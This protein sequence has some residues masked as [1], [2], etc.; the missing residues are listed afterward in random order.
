MSAKTKIVVL[1]MK[2]M[3]YTLIF[4]GLGILLILLLIFMF[5]P[6]ESKK[7]AETMNYVAGVYTSTIQFN[8]NT[9]DVQVVVD[10]SR[11][12]SV[13]LVNL[14]ETVT[15]MYPLM[16]PAVQEI[17]SQVCEKQSTDNIAYSEDNPYTSMVILNAV[18][19]A[20]KKA[21]TAP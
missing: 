20:L 13:S 3:I 1:H 17:A 11:I 21:E 10:E 15:T 18:K 9:I 6:K 7:T 8:D 5:L 2:E 4:A 12:Q 14:D 19:S 16:E